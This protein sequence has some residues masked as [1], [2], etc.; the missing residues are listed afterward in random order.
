[1]RWLTAEPLRVANGSLLGH[2]SYDKQ[3]I[4]C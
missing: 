4:N 1:M 3:D 2:Y